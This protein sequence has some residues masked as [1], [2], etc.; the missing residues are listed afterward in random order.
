MFGSCWK[1]E[2]FVSK[3]T[4][5][6]YACPYPSG[7]FTKTGRRITSSVA[8][9]NNESY[10]W[11]TY[12]DEAVSVKADENTTVFTAKL[13]DEGTALILTEVTDRVIPAGN[14]VVLR[15]TDETVTLTLDEMATGVLPNNALRGC[16]TKTATSKVG[17]TVYTL[18]A[19]SGELGFYRYT[20]ET[21]AARK[22]FLVAAAGARSIAMR[23]GSDATDISAV[24]AADDQ[25]G[26]TY[27]LS[28]RRT[29]PV[30]HIL[31]IN[32]GKKY[33]KK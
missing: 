19:E 12:Y 21:L 7:Y 1:L 24:S 32:N 28:G 11:A 3:N 14:A 27:D 33:V 26:A 16:Y 22:A 13:N 6:T 10:H 25:Q 5:A 2:G 8:V 23:Y 4:N 31:Y 20:G 15:S 29:K 18:A 9:L 17:G 30:K